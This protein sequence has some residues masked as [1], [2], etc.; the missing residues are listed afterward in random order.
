MNGEWISVEDRLP[1]DNT[2]CLI[3]SDGEYYISVPHFYKGRGKS[4]LG[5]RVAVWNEQ[6]LGQDVSATFTNVTHWMPLP[7]PPQKAE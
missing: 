5:K 2:R 6:Y 4:N 7:S 3:W 1:E